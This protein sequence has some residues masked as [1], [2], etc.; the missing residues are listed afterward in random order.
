LSLKATYQYLSENNYRRLFL[1]DSLGAALTAGLL[2]LVL[3]NFESF[4]GMPKTVLYW[5]TLFALVLSVFSFLSYLYG[6]RRWKILLLMIA[7]ANISYCML[8]SVLVFL[9]FDSLTF[10]G[11]LYFGVEVMIIMSLAIFELRSTRD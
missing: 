8:T 9:K 2:G 10:F 4:F 11:V 6:R 3:A 1:F 7:I 5:L